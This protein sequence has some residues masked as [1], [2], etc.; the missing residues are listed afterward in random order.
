MGKYKYKRYLYGTNSRRNKC[1]EFQKGS[2][3]MEVDVCPGFEKCMIYKERVLTALEIE[4]EKAKE[5][6]LKPMSFISQNRKRKSS[7]FNYEVEIRPKTEI[8]KYI[9]S[10]IEANGYFN[11]NM[12]IHT[13]SQKVNLQNINITKVYI[14][15]CEERHICTFRNKQPFSNSDQCV[16]AQFEFDSIKR[17]NDPVNKSKSSYYGT[18][19]YYG[20][21]L[22][23]KGDLIKENCALELCSRRL[24]L[25]DLI[26]QLKIKNSIYLHV[27]A[28]IIHQITPLDE[29]EISHIFIGVD[30][31]K[32]ELLF[33]KNNSFFT[34]DNETLSMGIL[35]HGVVPTPRKSLKNKSIITMFDETYSQI[36]IK[37]YPLE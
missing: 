10:E 24:V 14:G 36:S 15:L 16:N 1:P 34:S 5:E 19:D 7:R 26:D 11:M 30:E 22:V 18:D 31:Y 35:I 21:V 37:K 27:K 6:K 9:V 23:K 3:S 32:H 33:D 17:S 25:L 29:L 20:A 13:H 2:C 28:P 8:I 4:K 12:V